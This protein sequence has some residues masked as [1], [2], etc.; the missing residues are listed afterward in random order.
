M[1]SDLLDRPQHHPKEPI[2]KKVDDGENHFLEALK[3]LIPTKER[4]Q[5][6]FSKETLLALKKEE[7]LLG[8]MASFFG[9]LLIFMLE[10]LWKSMKRIALVGKV[11]ST[12]EKF[13]TSRFGKVSEK[14]ISKLERSEGSIKRSMLISLAFR[15]MSSKKTRSLVTVGGMSLGIAAIVFLVSIGYGLQELVVNRVARLE[16]LRMADVSINKTSNLKLNDSSVGSLL[17]VKKVESVLPIISLVGRISF[18]GAS[19]ETVVYGVTSKY[20]EESGLNIIKGEYFKNSDFSTKP[21]DS[22]VAGYSTHWDFEEVE[23]MKESRR[24]V[25]NLHADTAVRLRDEPNTNSLIMGLVRRTEQSLDGYEVWGHEFSGDERGSAARN[26]DGEYMGKWI[27]AAVPIWELIDGEMV[28]VIGPEGVQEWREGYLAQYEI[29]IDEQESQILGG[30]EGKVLGDTTDTESAS[31]SALVVGTDDDGVEWVELAD[32]TESAQISNTIILD[33]PDNLSKKTTINTALAE[34]L[35]MKPNES[36]GQTFDVKFVILQSLKPDLERT[37]ESK[38]IEYEIIG[39]FEDNSSGP[40]AYVPLEDLRALGVTQYSQARILVE[41]KKYLDE[42]RVFIDNMGYK[43]T[44]VSD[45]LSQIDK[46]FGSARLVLGI[47]GMVAL[48]VASLG[49]FN[50]LTVSLMERTREVGVM[51]ALGMKSNEVKE[52]FL[53]EAMAMG[54]VG[55]ILGVIGGVLAGKLLGLVLSVIAISKGVGFISISYVPP[56]F[57]FVVLF[58][59][60]LVGILTGIYPAR[61]A[62]KISALNALRYE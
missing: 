29:V 26:V 44:S 17:N 23:Y 8:S 21:V 45:T 22:R 41:D 3:G 56:I 61:R 36:I 42:A 7:K 54:L 53:A 62:T 58:L 59:S 24:V 28:P 19:S 18:D 20:L 6:N 15:N 38:S 11:F 55:G 2:K 13:W 52:L 51:K 37:A 9:L 4:F 46:L 49:M 33:T 10:L 48:V 32:S 39:V 60:F 47:F 40:V 1:I 31:I 5:K 43:T 16:E 27:R 50:T 34:I 14:L 57:M 35:G 30:A 25:F 12:A